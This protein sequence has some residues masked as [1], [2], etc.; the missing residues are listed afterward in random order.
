[1]T[2]RW[3]PAILP[4]TVPTAAVDS[5]SVIAQ[6]PGSE[7]LLVFADDWG[8]HPSSSQHLVRL[9]LA[10]HPVYWVNT[11]G[12]RSP[13]FDVATLRR[14]LEK[15]K[16]WALSSSGQQPVPGLSVLNPKMWPWFGTALDRRLNRLLLKW[17]LAPLLEALPTPAIAVSMLPIVADL[18]GVLPVRRWV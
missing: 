13:H 17:Q 16:G 6:A 3:H 5:T 9:L 18:V 11:I 1:L 8:R 2:I 4:I 7:P 10:R 12:T 15:L 14:S